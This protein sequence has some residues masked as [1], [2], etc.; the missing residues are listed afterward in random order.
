MTATPAFDLRGVL[1]NSLLEWE[2]RIAAVAVTGGCPWRCVYCHSWRYVTGLSKIAPLPLHTLWDTLERQDGWLDGVVVSGGE[3]TIQPGLADVLAEIKARGLAV[4]LH[5]N[6][7]RPDV[8]ARL[9]ADGLVNTLALD[10][11][12]PPDERLARVVGVDLADD[13]LA[14][15]RESL[16]LA[17]DAV[18]PLAVEYHTTLCP[19]V[20]DSAWLDELPRWMHASADWFLQPYRA[21]DV[22]DPA[23][24]GTATFDAPTLSAMTDRARAMHPGRVLLRG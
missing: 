7:T 18:P 16:A 6:G 4:K 11:K 1:T 22:L 17:R 21:D 13:D 5:T 12:A 3:P 8:V 24:A 9:L 19:A 10:L 14:A 15:V 2:D 20:F 23:R